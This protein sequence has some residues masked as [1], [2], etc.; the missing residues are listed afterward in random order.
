ML[1]DRFTAQV[2]G[3]IVLVMTILIDVSCFIFTKPEISHRPT[4]PLVVLIPSLPLFAVSFW[5]FRRAA[6][7]KVEED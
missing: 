4:F 1:T 5:L 2:L 7:L 6:R 3:A